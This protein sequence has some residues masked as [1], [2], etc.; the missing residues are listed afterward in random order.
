MF[1]RPLFI[2]LCTHL[3]NITSAFGTG[4]NAAT[5]FE[6][7]GLKPCPVLCEMAGAEATNWTRYQDTDFLNACDRKPK[8][9]NYIVRR[10]SNISQQLPSV[11]RACTWYR[12]RHVYEAQFEAFDELVGDAT[13]TEVRVTPRVFVEDAQHR[14]ITPQFITAIKEAQ[15]SLLFDQHDETDATTIT[16]HYGNTVVGIHVGAAI[17][18][19]GAAVLAVSQLLD[20]IR[21]PK[22][23]SYSTL[24]LQICGS[25]RPADYTLGVFADNTPGEAFKKVRHA[26]ASWQNATCIT[27]AGRAVSFNETALWNKNATTS[28]RL[29]DPHNSTIVTSSNSTTSTRM[30]HHSAHLHRRAD[31]RTVQ[32]VSGDSCASLATKCGIRGADFTKYNSGSSFCSTLRVG[33]RACCSSGNLPDV[34]PKPNSDGSCASYLVKAGDWCDSIAAANGL[35]V[36]ELESLNQ[37]TWGWSGCTTLYAGINMCLSSGAPPM[38][39]PIENAVCGPQKP[40]TTK[41]A[42]GVNIADLNQCPLKACC[43]VWGQCG[44]TS[45]FCMKSSLGPPGTSAP[46][47]NGCISNC[48][49][50]IFKGSAPTQFIKLGYFEAWNLR[51]RPCLHMD[52]TQI[53]SSYTHVHFAFG[54]ITPQFTVSMGAVQEQ[55]DKFVKMRGP[56]RVLAFGGWTASTSPSSY[57]IFREG[58]KAGNREILSTNIANFINDNGLDGVD[59]DWEYPGAPDIPGIPSADPIDGDNYLELLRLL[60]SKLS[61]KYILIR[62]SESFIDPI[63]DK[64]LSIAA[65]ASFWYLKPFPIAEIA[66]TVDY[67]VYMTYD[68]HGRKS[69]RGSSQS[70]LTLV[71]SG[72]M[73]VNGLVQVVQMAIVC[74]PT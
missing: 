45:E 26:L 31:C 44:T 9:L 10:P 66:K 32:V 37:N 46:G 52:V 55:F 59:L 34:R 61:S 71:Q 6:D 74:V 48:G 15:A 69:F 38:P 25:G 1:L 41:P 60:R 18:K 27:E 22:S 70:Q 4:V 13:L 17:N 35:T 58:V 33:Q 19:P 53:D 24:S 54:D 16:V 7:S 43:N 14:V 56:K 73:A 62:S 28:A 47:E 23:P 8:L 30:S 65:P 2:L 11:I 5:Y 68:L 39:A 40:G 51:E 72:I 50:D 57:Y 21:E 29:L 42:S 64:S 36:K 63:V 3:V 20:F 12:G 67:I 49:T